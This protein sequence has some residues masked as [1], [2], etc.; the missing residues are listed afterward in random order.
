MLKG[1]RV[2]KNS[3]KKIENDALNDA[4]PKVECPIRP[5]GNR[6]LVQIRAPRNKTK[7]GLVI[8]SD[9]LE[10]TYRNEQT[11]TIVKM[12]EGCFKFSTTGEPWPLGEWFAEGDF[13]RVP[14]HGG[15]NHWIAMKDG[16]SQ[17]LILFK[18]FRDYEIIGL[19][20]GDP[21]EVKTNMAYF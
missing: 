21:L 18:T 10:D 16:D 4:F 12:G 8:T 7:G 9:T 13:V 3:L 2:K 19:I 5:L 1:K 17:R 11:A 14:L 20:E 15:D 6:V